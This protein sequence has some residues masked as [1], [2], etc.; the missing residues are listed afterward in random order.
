MGQKFFTIFTDVATAN[1]WISGNIFLMM[2]INTEIFSD[3]MVIVKYRT[4][5]GKLN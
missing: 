5:N 4:E 2:E 1:A 3:G